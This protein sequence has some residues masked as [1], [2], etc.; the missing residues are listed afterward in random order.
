MDPIGFA[1]ENYDGIGQ[2]R[3]MD[4]GLPVDA[5]GSVTLDGTQQKF[6]DAVGLAGLLS[7]SPE[8]RSCFAGEWSRYALSRVDTDADAVSLQATASAFSTDTATLQDL[9]VA[10]ATMRSFRYRSLSPGETP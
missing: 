5:T 2:Y 9:M 8:V 1:F 6:N 3:T 7:K 10:A 4:N